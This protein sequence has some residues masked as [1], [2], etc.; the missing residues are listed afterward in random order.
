MPER[1]ENELKK[2]REFEPGADLGSRVAEGPRGEP[3]PP[4]RQRVIAGV[5][6]LVVFAAAAILAVRVF[7]TGSD[8]P[9]VIAPGPTAVDERIVIELSAGS[10]DSQAPEATMRYGDREQHG[11]AESYSW[12]VGDECTAGIADFAFYPPVG[13]FIVAPPGTPIEFTGDGMVESLDVTD[14]D[15][16]PIAAASLHAVPDANGQYVLEVNATWADTGGEHG[17]SNF[18]FGVQALSSLSAAPDVLHVDCSAVVARADTAVV[19]TQADGLHV[20]FE[21]TDGFD[22]YGI[23]TPE[24]TPSEE[25]FG[26]GGPFPF[27]SHRGVAV[28][29]GVWEIGC[30]S[31]DR[32]VEAGDLTTRF[33]LVDPDD[34]WASYELGCGEPVE[35]S[36]TSSIPN[37]VAHEEATVQL[38]VGLDGEDRLR[39]AG[40]GAE[41][42]ML[43]ITYVV[44]RGGVSVARLV[45]TGG[46]ETWQGTL[47]TCPESGIGLG[48]VPTSP[49]EIPADVPDL[50]VLR[51][52]GFGPAADSEYVRLQSDG[53]HIEA[54]NVADASAIVVSADDGSIPEDLLP[55]ETATEEFVIDVPAGSYRFGCRVESQG[56][57]L[58]GPPGGAQEPYVQVI[59]LPA[60]G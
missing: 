26:V 19:R 27:E 48:P 47:A 37:S 24:G 1:W 16:E 10:G 4:A 59:V 52:E 33:E 5:T 56:G 38:V 21:G 34:H 55:F 3:S 42:Y 50:L 49:P 11:V 45:L 35:V 54:T 15:G 60:E 23:V 32:P 18:F 14:P 25:S 40:Y 17:E 12:C 30:G 31:R 36:F 13:E 57:E 20:V 6:A 58:E 46:T 51:C 8:G 22:E 43:G 41:G 28:D 9:D 39:G 53:L 2:L 44:D 7:G 29:P